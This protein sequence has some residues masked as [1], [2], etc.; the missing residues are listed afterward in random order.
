L[1]FALPAPPEALVSTL[2]ARELPLGVPLTPLTALFW[3]GE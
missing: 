3:M 1:D 2:A